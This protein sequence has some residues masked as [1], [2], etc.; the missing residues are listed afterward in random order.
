[1]DE[2]GVAMTPGCAMGMP[3]PGFF[4]IVFSAASDDEFA[5]AMQRIEKHF[6]RF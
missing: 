1:M 2:V 3:A 6:A 5:T 4:R